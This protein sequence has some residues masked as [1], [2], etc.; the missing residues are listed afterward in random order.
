MT[1]A[2]GNSDE[3]LKLKAYKL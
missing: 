3:F 1:Q 2:N